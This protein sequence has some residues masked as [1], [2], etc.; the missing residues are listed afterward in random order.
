M[1]FNV[2]IEVMNNNHQLNNLTSS[3]TEL[4]E[5]MKIFRNQTEEL[6]FHLSEAGY[7]LSANEASIADLYDK[8]KLLKDRIG[9]AEIR[10]TSLGG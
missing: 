7:N 2:T 1:S 8:E 9:I 4:N 6:D 10:I 5:E 3:L